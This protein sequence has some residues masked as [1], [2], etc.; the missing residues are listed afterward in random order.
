MEMAMADETKITD[1]SLIAAEKVIGTTVYNPAGEKLGSVEDIMMDKVS[2]RTCYA[3]LSFGGFL[4]MGDKHS[5]LP[6]SELTYDRRYEGFVVNRDKKMLEKAPSY[7][8]DDFRWT[9]DYG[10]TVDRYYNAPSYWT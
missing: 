2:G 5:P 1:G 3:V 6:W 7:D 9:P 8:T 4:G 10:R